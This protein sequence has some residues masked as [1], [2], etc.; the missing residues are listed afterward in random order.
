MYEQFFNTAENKLLGKRGI[1]INL[2]Y[3]VSNS[4][5]LYAVFNYN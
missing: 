2:F 3:D 1:A 5:L 4:L